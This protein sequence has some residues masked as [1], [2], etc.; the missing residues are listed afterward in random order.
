MKTKEIIEKNIK[1]VALF[2]CLVLV[3]GIV[4]DVLSKEIYLLDVFGYEL[5]SEHLISDNKTPI[6]KGITQL[7]GV[8]G[9]IAI[10]TILSITIIHMS[11]SVLIIPIM[12]NRKISI[13]A[14]YIRP[15]N[16]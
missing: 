4:I 2:I 14:I 5:V 3:I 13:M 7:G 10:A 6:V 1:W 16:P 15:I 8:I 12:S 9:L 11:F